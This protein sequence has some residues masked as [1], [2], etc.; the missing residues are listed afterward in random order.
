MERTPAAVLLQDV[1]PKRMYGSTKELQG[2]L[3]MNVY[4]ANTKYP[5]AGEIFRGKQTAEDLLVLE[6]DMASEQHQKEK[7]KKAR[8]QEQIGTITSGP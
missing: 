1:L 6:V 3:T 5:T 7:K 2:R 4:K 8:S